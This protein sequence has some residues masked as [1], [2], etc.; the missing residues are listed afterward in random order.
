MMVI[1]EERKLSQKRWGEAPQS[2]ASMKKFVFQ[3]R[4]QKG[5]QISVSFAVG[6][7]S[8]GAFDEAEIVV[9]TTGWG[10]FVFC[11]M[12]H[13]NML[14]VFE[15]SRRINFLH[16]E[17]RRGNRKRRE[18]FFLFLQSNSMECG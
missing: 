10:P 15:T 11:G 7:C 6:K 4:L 12:T 17:S 13:G 3:R 14:R 5:L 16:A 9:L 2:A 1:R 8:C 18:H